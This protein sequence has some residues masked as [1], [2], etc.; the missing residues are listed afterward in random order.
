MKPIKTKTNKAVKLFRI[1]D[2]H[3]TE[4]QLKQAKAWYSSAKKIQQKTH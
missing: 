4:Q 1:M 2:M 3:I